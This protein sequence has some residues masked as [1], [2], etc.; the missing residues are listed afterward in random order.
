MNGF[1]PTVE[2]EGFFRGLEEQ[3]RMGVEKGMVRE[4]VAAKLSVVAT[5]EE[6]MEC[7]FARSAV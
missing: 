3:S 5:A 6:A 7:L 1:I 2:R 4:E